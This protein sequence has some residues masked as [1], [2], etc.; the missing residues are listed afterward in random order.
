[1]ATSDAFDAEWDPELEAALAASQGE[2]ELEM[3]LRASRLEF[4]RREED[5]ELQKALEASMFEAPPA[6]RGSIPD[7][8]IQGA[9]RLSEEALAKDVKRA[10]LIRKQ[11]DGSDL[12]QAALRASK[13][14]LGPR[15][16]SQV[17]KIMATGDPSLG[18][19]SVVAKMPSKMGMRPELKKAKTFSAGPGQASAA[20]G[21]ADSKDARP[22]STAGKAGSASTTLRDTGKA[23]L[24]RT[25]K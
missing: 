11:E 5:D 13:V 16:I 9:L 17:A 1:M 4:A 25:G 8:E 12:F 14:D 23:A 21:Q 6:R 2:S 22:G 19:A 18:K 3:A 7:A 10:E 24:G 20:S 15:G